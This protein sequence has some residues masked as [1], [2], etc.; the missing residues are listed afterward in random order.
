[1]LS[2]CPGCNSWQ[3]SYK[4]TLSEPHRASVPWPRA[5]ESRLGEERASF[6]PGLLK[7]C[8]SSLATVLAMCL[9]G[10]CAL[11]V[12]SLLQ[13]GLC[14]MEPPAYFTEVDGQSLY[15]LDFSQ[16]CYCL[17]SQVVLDMSYWRA[18][19]HHEAAWGLQ[20]ILSCFL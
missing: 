11:S 1:M 4:H 7:R 14:S 10:K 15:F 3:D 8:Y 9:F 6:P 16:I 17:P 12:F 13:R 2:F 20:I 19:S 18:R 5:L